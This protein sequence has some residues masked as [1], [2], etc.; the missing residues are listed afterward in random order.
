MVTQDGETGKE[1]ERRDLVKGYEFRKN[2]YVLLDDAD[3]DSVKVESS[4][5]MAVEKFVDA[6]SIDPVY[7]VLPTTWHPMVMLAA[8][9]MRCFARR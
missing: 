6:D 8:T 5:V 9:C 2:E 7:Y 3:F 1:L 4:A